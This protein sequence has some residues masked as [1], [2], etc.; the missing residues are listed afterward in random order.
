M[1]TITFSV[2]YR[3]IIDYLIITLRQIQTFSYSLDVLLYY[4]R[5]VTKNLIH[6]QG[7][8]IYTNT[9]VG[10]YTV[11][12]LTELAKVFNSRPNIYI[13]LKLQ[14]VNFNNVNYRTPSTCCKPTLS[15]KNRNLKSEF[16]RNMSRIIK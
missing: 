16:V 1:L 9:V 13:R 8:R 5:H 11:T 6:S 10:W 7:F 2:P 12:D 4:T 14:F 3:C 15:Y